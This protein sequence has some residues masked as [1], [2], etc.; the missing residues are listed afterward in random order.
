MHLKINGSLLG[1]ALHQHEH[2]EI[3][4]YYLICV[5]LFINGLFI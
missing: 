3:A 5:R 2:D 4:Y 1:K